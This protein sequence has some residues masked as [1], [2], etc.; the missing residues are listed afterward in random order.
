MYLNFVCGSYSCFTY[1]SELKI[2]SK[3]NL[4]VAIASAI[5]FLCLDQ[6]DSYKYLSQL[7]TFYKEYWK[8]IIKGKPL[9][10]NIFNKIFQLC[11]QNYF[12]LLENLSIAKTAVI[13]RAYLVVI[14]LKLKPNNIFNLR[15]YRKIRGYTV[16]LSQNSRLL[17]TLLLFDLAVFENVMYIV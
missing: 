8:C 1:I 14:I 3:D 7:Y 15:A 11:C 5:G 6:F 4:I 17:L 12:L 13:T 16:F 9:K 10:Y 2:I